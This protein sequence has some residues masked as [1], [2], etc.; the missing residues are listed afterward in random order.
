M[1]QKGPIG[2]APASALS[3]MKILFI[4]KYDVSGGAAIAPWRLHQQLERSGK[5]EDF[6]LVGIKKSSESYVFATRKPGIENNIERGVNLILNK[7]G[8]QYVW[9]PFSTGRIK[10]ITARIKPDVIA[11]Q[12]IHGGYFKTEL[13]SKLSRI[14]PVVWTLHDMWAFTAN[15]AYVFGDESWK[16]MQGG[17]EEKKYFPTMGI[18]TGKWLLKRKKKIYTASRLTVV[19]PSRWM[20][21]LAR[22]SPVFEGKEMVCIPNGIDTAFFR[23]PEDKNKIRKELGISPE[24]KVLLLSAEKLLQSDYKGGKD[25]LEVLRLLDRPASDG[26]TLLTLG[27]DSL[28][29]SYRY[30]QVRSMGYITD[31]AQ[32]RQALQASDLFLH[33]A[34]A[35]NLPNT[36]IEAIACG[37]PCVAFDI[38]GC[39][40]IVKDKENGCL[41]EPFDHSLFADSVWSLVSNP[42]KC[43]LFSRN[44]RRLAEH[45]FDVRLMAE[46]YMT[47]F[48]SLANN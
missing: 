21:R 34:R 20:E 47:L 2:Y 36:L 23:P 4:N 39:G 44:A 14:A 7:L 10:K 3:L 35:D 25:L 9:F 13:V 11:L 12:N 41:I 30:L 28:P 6:F 27:R 37:V 38:G 5:T 32:I 43:Q 15:A 16:Q 48:K 31:E 40:D 42:E 19:C 24:Q 17:K 1:T 29:A 45:N 22:Q 8:L 46:R 26:I 33:T 18:N